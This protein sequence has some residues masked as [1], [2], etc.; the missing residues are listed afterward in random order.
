MQIE[1]PHQGRAAGT[2]WDPAIYEKFAD[3]RLRPAF[4]LLARIPHIEP[5][6]IYDLG[7]GTGEVTR[8]IADRWPEA[9]VIGLDNSP[10][11]LSKAGRIPSRV[12]WVERDIHF[13]R[14]N[15]P[16]DLIYSNATLQ[17]VDDHHT[18]FPRLIEALVPAGCLALQMPLSWAL[19]SHRLMRETLADGG[20]HG[21][22]LGTEHLRQ[23]VGRNW[24]DGADDYYRLLSKHVTSLDIW[25]TE[26]LQVL[27]GENPVFD[28]VSGT[29]LRPI[30]NGLDE[31]DRTLFVQEYQSRL[32]ATYMPEPDGRTLYPFRRLFI[33]ATT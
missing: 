4:E 10:E 7:C 28:W 19:P 2:K 31:P 25:E 1:Q 23:A 26:Y 21:N 6:L 3:Q 22:P 9:N 15:V 30:L 12:Q 13:W 17:W 11:M 27:E 18:L 24:V 8:A 14:A 29:G 5:K 20:T 33:V 32:R 16:T